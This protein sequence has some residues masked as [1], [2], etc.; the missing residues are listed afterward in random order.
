[1]SYA[2]YGESDSYVHLVTGETPTHALSEFMDDLNSVGVSISNVHNVYAVNGRQEA[3]EIEN[4][5]NQM[6]K[7]ANE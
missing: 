2:I 1:M 6:I 5:L 3:V 4:A 7:A